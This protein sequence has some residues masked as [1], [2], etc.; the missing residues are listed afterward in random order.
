MIDRKRL[1][2]S[3]RQSVANEIKRQIIVE[4]L[5]YEQIEKTFK[6]N[7]ITLKQKEGN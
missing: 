4:H 2:E 1:V 7:A 3:T 6:Q 5:A